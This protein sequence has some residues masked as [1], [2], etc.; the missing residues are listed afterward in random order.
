M[1]DCTAKYKFNF[2][3]L[4]PNKDFRIP[5]NDF[6][7]KKPDRWPAAFIHRKLR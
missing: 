1:N 7:V 2:G 5:R 6:T 3:I 4:N